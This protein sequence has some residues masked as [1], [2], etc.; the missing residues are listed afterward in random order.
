MNYTKD[1]WRVNSANK[2]E[3][4]SFNGIAIADCSMSQMITKEEK[5]ANAK[6]I[7]LAPK[8]LEALK[9]IAEGKGRYDT[10]KLKHASN[11]IEDMIKLATD[12]ISTI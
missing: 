2:T 3:V 11:T 1:E 6:L 8:M 9:E 7:A 12:A 10:D 5:E 4:N